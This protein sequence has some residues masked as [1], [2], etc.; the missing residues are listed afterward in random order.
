MSVSFELPGGGKFMIRMGALRQVPPSGLALVR[1]VVG[2]YL[3]DGRKG[4][5]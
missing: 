2:E 1:G 3:T 4:N 5:T